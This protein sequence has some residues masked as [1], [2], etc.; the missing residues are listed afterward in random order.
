MI[1]VALEKT[2]FGHLAFSNRVCRSLVDKH[3]SGAVEHSLY[4]WILFEDHLVIL[5]LTSGDT[6]RVVACCKAI[7]AL[8]NDLTSVSCEGSPFQ[9]TSGHHWSTCRKPSSPIMGD[10]TNG[11]LPLPSPESNRLS[12]IRVKQSRF[13]LN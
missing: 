11:S 8:M 5:D 6:S 7:S 10:F 4:V 12:R 2:L 1:L 9:S 13:E 3:C